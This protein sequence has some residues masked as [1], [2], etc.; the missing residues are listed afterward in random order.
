[1]G[2]GKITGEKLK[3]DWFPGLNR[4]EKWN[5]ACEKISEARRRK[6]VGRNPIHLPWKWWKREDKGD[7]Q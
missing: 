6:V 4:A 2:G 3:F 1:M 7:P 5:G